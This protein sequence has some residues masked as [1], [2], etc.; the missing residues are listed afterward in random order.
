MG[1]AV[2]LLAL[3][4]DKSYDEAWESLGEFAQAMIKRPDWTRLLERVRSPLGSLRSRTPSSQEQRETLP[5]LPD[6]HYVVYTFDS[7]F[8]NKAKGAE[9]VTCAMAV[10][11]EWK[12]IGY[13]VS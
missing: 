1:S 8:Q 9:T 5:G 7:E 12:A 3:I 4:D 11:G 10:G 2:A 6:G 13:Q